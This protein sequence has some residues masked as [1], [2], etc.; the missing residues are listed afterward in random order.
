MS[1]KTI[2]TL[3]IALLVVIVGIAG[4]SLYQDPSAA[5][6]VAREAAALPGKVGDTLLPGGAPAQGA[7]QDGAAAAPETSFTMADVAAHA[8]SASCYTAIDGV[9]YDLTPFISR[10]PGGVAAISTLCGIDGTAGFKQMH[11]RDRKP[12]NELAQLR[13]GVIAQ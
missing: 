9:V 7:S 12:Q 5:S 2:F 1:N 6:D 8:S 11:A 13:I 10:H 3:I 4:Y